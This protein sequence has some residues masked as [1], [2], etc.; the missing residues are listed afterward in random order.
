M[1]EFKYLDA[2]YSCQDRQTAR[3]KV[4][5]I[6]DH[7]IIYYDIYFSDKSMPKMIPIYLEERQ[8]RILRRMAKDNN[9]SISSLIRKSVDALLDQTPAEKDPAWK[10][11]GLSK[12]NVSDLASKHDDYLVK[13][14]KKEYRKK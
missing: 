11:I 9:V 3:V 10:I 7:D 13:E 8:E 1:K 6:A 4:D 12:S 5:N 14:I 2:E